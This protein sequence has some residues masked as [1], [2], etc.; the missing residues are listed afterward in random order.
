MQLNCHPYTTN[1]F[2]SRL[3]CLLSGKICMTFDIY[4]KLSGFDNDNNGFP[5]EIVYL[6][7][8]DVKTFA[9]TLN[10]LTRPLLSF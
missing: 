3:L 1:M 4:S 10:L 7:Q 8:G 5:I 2:T 6:N 9:Q